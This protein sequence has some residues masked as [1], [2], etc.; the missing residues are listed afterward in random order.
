[1]CGRE[2]KSVVSP[3][4]KKG[5]LSLGKKEKHSGRAGGDDGTL[6][7]NRLGSRGERVDAEQTGGFRRTERP[8]GTL[9]NAR[10]KG[11]KGTAVLSKRPCASAEGPYNI[12]KGGKKKKTESKGKRKKKKKKKDLL[13][14]RLLSAKGRPM[15]ARRKRGGHRAATFLEKEPAGQVSGAEEKGQG[16]AGGGGP[17][18]KGRFPRESRRLKKKRKK[19]RGRSAR[20]RNT[21]LP[22]KGSVSAL[23]Q[24]RTTSLKLR[25]KTQIKEPSGEKVRFIEQSKKGKQQQQG[26]RDRLKCWGEVKRGKGDG[27]LSLWEATVT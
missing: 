21:I 25:K 17:R 13:F 15:R 11:E 16:L 3:R 20:G 24:L 1:V 27:N 9:K 4:L 18:K 26:K 8:A 22:A 6:E 23:I 14:R 5:G 2:R 19:A 7:G 12:T 10:G